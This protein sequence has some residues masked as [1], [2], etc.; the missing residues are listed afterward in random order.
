MMDHHV[1]KS[2]SAGDPSSGKGLF[3]K[4]FQLQKDLYTPQKVNAPLLSLEALAQELVVISDEEWGKYAFY[5]DPIG[6]K[7]TPEEKERL[8]G[9]SLECGDNYARECTCGKGMRA[10]SLIAKE[11]GVR[12]EYPRRPAAKALEGNRV[13]FAQYTTP[14]LI[15]VFT[16]CTGK[17]EEAF[18]AL[19]LQ[20][21]LGKVNIREILLAHELFHYYEYRDAKTI[22]TENEKKDI[23]IL[24]VFHNRSRILC[25]GEIA[26]MRFAKRIVDLSYSPYVYD[27]LLAYLYDRQTACNLYAGIQRLLDKPEDGI[28]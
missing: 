26:A 6:G 28:F 2:A 5:R 11:L 16:D 24:G 17:A 13:L 9:L 8:I 4:L 15:E 10:P 22:F 3:G 12:V 1:L 27:V 14:D 7:F 23:P 20:G 19:P 21:I 25:L 18:S